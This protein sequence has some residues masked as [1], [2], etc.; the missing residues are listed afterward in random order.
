M[1][2]N[3]TSK[4][5][6]SQKRASAKR[7]EGDDGKKNRCL[8][9]TCLFW[10]PVNWVSS[11]MFMLQSSRQVPPSSLRTQFTTAS[12]KLGNYFFPIK[13]QWIFKI[14]LLLLPYWWNSS[15]RP[16]CNCSLLRFNFNLKLSSLFVYWKSLTFPQSTRYWSRCNVSVSVYS[17][18][19][20]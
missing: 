15:F 5:H 6:R 20:I 12:L 13:I 8:Y 4:W 3:L 16:L 14:T 1:R 7:R 19:S 18:M 9:F 17:N 11:I 2:T 10:Q